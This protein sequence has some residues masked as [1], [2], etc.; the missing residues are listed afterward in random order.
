MQNLT[1]FKFFQTELRWDHMYLTQ[2]DTT[3]KLELSN[4]FKG[5]FKPNGWYSSLNAPPMKIHARIISDTIKRIVS[6]R[7]EKRPRIC[8]P[9]KP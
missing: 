6:Q 3:F 2:H 5:F 1:L 7:L 9:Q 4:S 8:C